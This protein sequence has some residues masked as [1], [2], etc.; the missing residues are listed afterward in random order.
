MNPTI[1][2]PTT[3]G[4]G[5]GGRRV[6]GS[7]PRITFFEWTEA[8]I[9]PFTAVTPRDGET[10]TGP[11][12]P[13]EHVR[14]AL[15]FDEAA[16]RQDDRPTLVYFHWPHDDAQHGKLTTAVCTRVMNDEQSARWG[17]LFRCVQVDMSAT[18]AKY[19]EMVGAGKGPSIVALDGDLEV[20]A[21]IPAVKSSTKLS[22]ALEKAFGKFPAYRKKIG[23]LLAQQ[24]KWLDRARKLEKQGELEEALEL[25][26]KIRFGSL[27]VGPEYDKAYAYGLRL[28]QKVE[29][30]KDDG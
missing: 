13:R 12:T 30:S 24:A 14:A 22:K 10:V 8:T 28:A 27:R 3:P 11:K 2:D 18:E 19:A 15:G 4:D 7:A 17:R 1:P 25:V 20:L 21:R 29:Q 23:R 26:D 9:G 5:R 6:S 16:K